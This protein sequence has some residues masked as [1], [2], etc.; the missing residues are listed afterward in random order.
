MSEKNIYFKAEQCV[1]VHNKKVYIDDIVKICGDDKKLVKE[2]KSEVLFT[3]TEEKKAK[4]IFS[5]LKIIEVL[6][7]KHPNI[8]ITSLGEADI[9]IEYMPPGHKSKIIEIAKI[10]VIC[11]ATFFGSAFTIMTFNEDVSVNDILNTIYS[12]VK[13]NEPT[14][15]GILQISYAVGLPIGVAAFFNHFSKLKMNTDPTPL[16]VEL[17]LYEYDVNQ[18]IIQNASREGK[19]KDV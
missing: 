17:R 19:E 6:M 14:K 11:L 7:A 15:G 4:Y 18:A 9:I 13:M 3:V 2:L 8:N 1:E 10:T 12:L 5:I 16:Q